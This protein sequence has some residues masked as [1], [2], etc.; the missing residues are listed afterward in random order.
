MK[1]KKPLN[2]NVF[3]IIICYALKLGP[4]ESVGSESDIQ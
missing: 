1:S 2:V 4:L 3:E